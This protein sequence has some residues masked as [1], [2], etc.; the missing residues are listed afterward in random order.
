MEPKTGREQWVHFPFVLFLIPS[1]STNSFLPFFIPCFLTIIIPLYCFALQIVSLRTLPAFSSLSLLLTAS[2]PS[3]V[4]E[5]RSFVGFQI[6]TSYTFG[7]FRSDGRY[8][9]L[10]LRFI[11]LSSVYFACLVFIIFCLFVHLG[12]C[13]CHIR[14]SLIFRCI[15]FIFLLFPFFFVF[16]IIT[17]RFFYYSVSVDSSY[18]A[19]FKFH[20]FFIVIFYAFIYIFAIYISCY[21]LSLWSS[22]LIFLSLHSFTL[23]FLVSLLLI[24]LSLH[25]ATVSFLVSLLLI[26]FSLHHAT[27]SFHVSFLLA[28]LSPHHATLSFLASLL[29]VGP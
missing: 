3:L 22:S 11:L 13:C 18:L 29:V 9:Y 6:H 5:V 14:L 27:L 26:F 17:F 25:H 1:H 12:L 4:S 21:L 15:C 19:G 2:S 24:F 7:F 10:V 20:I 16:G 28:F 23:P 8:V